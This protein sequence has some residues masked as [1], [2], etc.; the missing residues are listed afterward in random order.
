MTRVTR[1]T[2]L[3]RRGFLGASL[4][5]AGARLLPACG[6]GRSRFDV[7]LPI[8]RVLD[9]VESTAEA[10]IYELTM[11]KG[12]AQIL[13]GPA[14]EIW[15]YDGEW[16]GPTIRARS[17]RAAIVRHTNQLPEQTSVHLH[18]AN[19]PPDSDGHPNDFF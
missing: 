18:G 13:D 8:P 12:E 5:L 15:G 2:G 17:G 1:S 14:T 9:P 3:S 16:P 11:K 19:T 4:A 7:P 10:D 6:A